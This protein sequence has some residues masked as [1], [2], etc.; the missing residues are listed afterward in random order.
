VKL[1][2]LVR[3]TS[4][5]VV[6]KEL[7]GRMR[8]ARAFVFVSLYQFILAG[9]VLLVYGTWWS[10][11]RM[12]GHSNPAEA[13][14][15]LFLV[16]VGFQLVATTLLAPAFTA[17]AIT[18]E[19]QNKTF[20][21]LRTTLLPARSI[22]SGKLVSALTFLLMMEL[23]SLP[24]I[25][26]AFLLGGITLLEFAIAFVLMVVTA[27]SFSAQGLLISSLAR[28]T[29][30]STV[31]S[32]VSLLLTVVV[33]PIALLIG[34]SAIDSAAWG[35]YRAFQPPTN[36][37]WYHLAFYVFWAILST[38]PIGA[39]ALSVDVLGNGNTSLVFKTSP[40]AGPD[41][42]VT[43]PWLIFVVY[44]LLLA[45]LLGWLCVRRVRRWDRR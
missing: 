15:V 14:E 43:A 12:Y 21:L 35:G 7:R 33:L 3:P 26:V 25:S 30:A 11:A 27:I 9:I 24:V 38:N 17:G 34:W 18:G 5:P 6:I 16:C 36:W 29:L 20:D 2:A 28:T 45:V 41:V 13:G 8:R 4:N 37:S 31:I 23:T 19:H 44:H 42:W 22:V 10:Q 1:S 32:Y 39:G 40:G